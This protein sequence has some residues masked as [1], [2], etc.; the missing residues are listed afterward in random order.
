MTYEIYKNI[1]TKEEYFS[2]W[3]SDNL[4]NISPKMQESIYNKYLVKSA[5]FQ[6]DKFKCK[7][8]NCKYPNS[9]LTLHHIKFKKNNGKD[10]LKNC[11]TICITCHQGFHRRK[12][13]LKFDGMEYKVNTNDKIDWKKIKAEGKTIRKSNKEFCGY[14][15]SWEMLMKIFKFLNIPYDHFYD[16]DDDQ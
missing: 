8:E 14:K 16:E 12:N 9:K 3:S 10:S 11:I 6:R 13:S 7:N 1:R 5:V 15:I 2:D 4:D